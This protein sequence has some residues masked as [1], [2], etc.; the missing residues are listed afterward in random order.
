L[1]T[2]RHAAVG[3]FRIDSSMQPELHV[4][5]GA[6][7]FTGRYI[8]QRLLAE[9]KRVLTLTGHPGRASPFG[10]SVAVA[11]FSFDD[12]AALAESLRGAAVLYN[13][14]WVRFDW[15][16]ESY[17]RAVANTRALIAAAQ[18][19]EVPRF[20]ISAARR[21]SSGR[22]ATPRSHTRFSGRR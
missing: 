22:S 4:V 5:T 3:T 15:G 18:R 17:E 21:S 1:K 14:Y 19:A 16:G 6:F 7:G 8:T 2:F 9:G 20:P 11:P 12:P 10:G 13:T